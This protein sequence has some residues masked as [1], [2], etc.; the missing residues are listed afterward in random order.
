MIMIM[1]VIFSKID[2]ANLSDPLFYV[3]VTLVSHLREKHKLRVFANSVLKILH[4]SK[5]E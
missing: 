2:E 5:V 4:A 3:R 1:M